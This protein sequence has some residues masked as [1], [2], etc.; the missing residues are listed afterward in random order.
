VTGSGGPPTA[1]L[2]DV[3]QDGIVNVSDVQLIVNEALGVAPPVN[4][5]NQ[6]GVV[7][8]VEVQLVIHAALGL[9][10]PAS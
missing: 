3:N 7:N 5:I 6:D 8:V 4:D 1:N 2:C 10:C 9:G